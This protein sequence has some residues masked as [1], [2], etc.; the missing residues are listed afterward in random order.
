[1]G[2]KVVNVF[3]LRCLQGLSSMPQR[4]ETLT[5]TDPALGDNPL[6]RLV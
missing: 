2:L 3:E 1:M 6:D 5:A 4:T